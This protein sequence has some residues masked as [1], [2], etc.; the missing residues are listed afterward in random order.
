MSE[1]AS[2]SAGIAD[3]YATA[4]FELA[5]DAGGVDALAAEVAALRGAVEVSGELREALRSPVLTREEQEG[6]LGALAAK[7]ELGAQVSNTLRLMAQKRRAFAVPA[8]L[9]SLS[10]KIAKE[11]G[12]VTAEVT[13]A[14]ALTKTQAEKLAKVLK[15]KTGQDVEI[16]AAVDESL[17]G[18]LVVKLGSQMV[19]TSVRSKLDALQNSMKEVG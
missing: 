6:A 5:R 2:I 7:L 8:L 13:S 17:I 19:D 10:E 3:R 12:I 15:A 9:D 16:N 1:S 14:K 11:K 4:L 18:G